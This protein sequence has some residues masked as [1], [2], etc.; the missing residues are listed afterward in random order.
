MSELALA[1]AS[2][3]RL[4]SLLMSARCSLLRCSERPRTVRRTAAVPSAEP[5]HRPSSDS[6]RPTSCG[7]C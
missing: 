5:T 4:A 6:D 1:T 3:R 2:A 7:C